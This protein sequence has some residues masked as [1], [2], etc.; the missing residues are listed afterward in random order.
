[1]TDSKTEGEKRIAV[2]ITGASGTLYGIRFIQQAARIWDRVWLTWSGNALAV[3]KQ[4]LDLDGFHP[5]KDL[6]LGQY[7]TRVSIMSAKDLTAP[8]SSGSYSYEGLVVVPCS[9][10][11]LGRIANGISSDLTT[12]I[13]DVCLKERRKLIL[14]N[15]ETP[16]S[17]I[18]LRNML[19]A[20]EAGATIMPAAPGLYHRPQ[21]VDDMVD[22]VVARILQ[23]LGVGQSL[24]P[25]WREDE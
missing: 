4:E 6:Q 11:T 12:R 7:A 2:S 1:M 22:F 21:S 3:A 13:A 8:P 19:T 20:A 17:T 10:G 24:V 15:R 25:G 18:H 23:S 16:L 9:M 14:V 5:E